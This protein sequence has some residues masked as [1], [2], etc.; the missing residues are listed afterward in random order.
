MMI[1]FEIM[2]G[3]SGYQIIEAP[4]H[5]YACMEILREIV[6]NEDEIPSSFIVTNLSDP[7]IDGNKEISFIDI[8]SMVYL[9]NNCGLLEKEYLWE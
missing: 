8:F 5:L 7:S 6:L 3:D 9:S 1:N 4:T 2:Y